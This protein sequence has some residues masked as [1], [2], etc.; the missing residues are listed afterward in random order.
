M[1]VMRVSTLVLRQKKIMEELMKS[2]GNLCVL[3]L[4]TLGTAFAQPSITGVLNAGSRIPSGF[5]GYG[6]AQGAVFAVTGTNL[7]SDPL[8]QAAF[9]LPTTDGL[10]GVAI[11]ASVGGSTV[12]CIM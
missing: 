1:R 4:V 12:D 11:Q 3:V 2:G 9:P 8:Q 7:G 6:I 5:P 10:G